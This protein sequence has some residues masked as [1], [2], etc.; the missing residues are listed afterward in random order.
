MDKYIE[1][2]KEILY[3][4]NKDNVIETTVNLLLKLSIM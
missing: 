4:N 1:Q 2:Y 3:N